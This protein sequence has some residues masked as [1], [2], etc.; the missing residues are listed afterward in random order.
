MRVYLHGLDLL[1]MFFLQTFHFFTRL[2]RNPRILVA[3][4]VD[5]SNV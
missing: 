1:G 2:D 4:S 3:L 5:I